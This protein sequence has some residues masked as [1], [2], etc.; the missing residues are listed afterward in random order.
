M[1]IRF[2]HTNRWRI[3]VNLSLA[4]LLTL[5]VFEIFFHEATQQPITIDPISVI[6]F[7]DAV[8]TGILVVDLV[9]WYSE[10]KDKYNFIRRNWIKIAAVF[11]FMMAFRGLQ[12]LRLQEVLAFA[13]SGQ[14]I[15]EILAIERLLGFEKGLRFV[16]KGTEF[17]REIFSAT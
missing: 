12:F 3:L 14:T 13:F 2:H 10:A 9:L 7:I 15:T 16:S 4:L 6:W 5:L 8:L 17:V 1:K 11:P